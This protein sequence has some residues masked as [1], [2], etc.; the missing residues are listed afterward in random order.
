[1]EK[2]E[3]G[4]AILIISGI[5]LL[6]NTTRFLSEI[7]IRNLMDCLSDAFVTKTKLN[8]LNSTSFQGKVLLT[9]IASVILFFTG[10]TSEEER[11]PFH[12]ELG[13]RP[14]IL[15]VVCEDISPY[16]GSY[17]DSAAY[18]PNLD[19]LAKEGVRFTNVFSVSG[20]CAPS[21]AALITGMYPTSFGANNMRTNR[22]DL[23]ELKNCPPY[24][25]VP[26]ADVKCYPE[27]MRAAGYYC[28][29]N[30]KEDYQFKAPGTAWDESSRHAH[31]RNRPKGANFFAIFNFIR[32]HESQIWNWLDE[33]KSVDPARVPVPPYYPDN[34]VVRKDIATLYTNITIMDREVGEVLAQLEKD[35]L[36]DSTIIIFYSDHGGP[37][38]RGKREILDSGLEVPMIIRFPGGKHGGTVNDDLI[39]F[40]DIPAT[41]L[42]MAGVEIPDYMH[43]QAFWGSQKSKPREYI[44]AAR[45]RMDGQ[46]DC[47]RAVRNKKFK[48]IRNYMPDEP[49]YMPIKFRLAMPTML[50]LLRMK[51]EGTLNEDQMYWFRENKETEELYNLEEDPYE[52]NNVADDPQYKEVLEELRAV[53]LEWME[54]INDPGP[55]SERELVAS[56]WPDL[57][58]PVT[59]DP[60]IDIQN[61]R[62]SMDCLT[63]GASIAYQ[64]NGKGYTEDHSFLYKGP[65]EISEDDVVRAKA[66]RIGYKPSEWVSIHE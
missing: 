60:A 29:N 64:I 42:S 22:K 4:L 8:M 51:E 24:E 57:I 40:V 28:T 2:K 21:R 63:E 9:K 25:A 33:P 36:M 50:E 56:M 47:R 38:P 66:Y 23:P 41:I 35:G 30:E 49:A 46:T 62:V 52:L 10:C 54:D 16:L 1:M 45:D 59:E 31:W 39:S 3:P 34:E 12:E 27:F 6:P 15:C 26:P 5:L 20:V 37:M 65:F 17:G 18:T 48:Y 19:N 7:I 11:D 55:I 32:S 13:F 14:N 43:G 53:H 44:F 58:Q 61:G